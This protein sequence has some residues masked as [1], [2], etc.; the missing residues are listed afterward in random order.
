MSQKRYWNYKDDD[1]TFA[2]NFKDLLLAPAGRYKGFTKGIS[3]GLTLSLLV[4]S[5]TVRVDEAKAFTDGVSMWKTLQGGIIE[6]D[7]TVD[8]TIESN[9]ANNLPRIDI[10]VGEHEYNAV[11]GG[12]VAI[13]KAI[14]GTPNLSPSAPALTDDKTQVILGEL[15]LPGYADSVSYTGV[16][17]TIAE[18]PQFNDVSMVTVATAQDVTGTKRFNATQTHI[19]EAL[20]VG[21]ELQLRGRSD[22]YELTTTGTADYTTVE[23][24]VYTDETGTLIPEVDNGHIFRIKSISALKLISADNINIPSNRYIR[25]NSVVT[26][27]KVDDSFTLLTGTE[28]QEGA[29]KASGLLG[30]K[31]ASM[32][33]IDVKNYLQ[34]SSVTSSGNYIV[35]DLSSLNVSELHGIQETFIDQAT[36]ASPHPLTGVGTILLML[37]SSTAVAKA[38]AGASTSFKNLKIS[39]FPAFL[40]Y[41]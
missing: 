15:Y 19:K 27:A 1:S 8:V 11:A 31:S 18:A 6:E 16:V 36:L 9:A 29:N 32:K 13:Y 30:F 14:A 34:F 22:Y 33:E 4:G 12:Q 5:G 40:R 35:A 17:Y 10:I 25:A 39:L 24:I 7:A 20:I 38:V 37:H 41:I 2:L 28:F 21:S 23:T 26:F 3:T